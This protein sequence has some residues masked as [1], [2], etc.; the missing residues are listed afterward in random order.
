MAEFLLEISL[1]VFSTEIFIMQKHLLLDITYLIKTRSG[2]E[3]NQEEAR[4]VWLLGALSAGVNLFFKLAQIFDNA[5]TTAGLS[6]NA[7]VAP[8]QD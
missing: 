6:R 4:A 7:G 1:Q 3:E 2:C 5:G 8:M